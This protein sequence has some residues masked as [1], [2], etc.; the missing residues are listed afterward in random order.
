VRR[1]LAFALAV[2]AANVGA[3]CDLLLQ[4]EFGAREPP[5]E[6]LPIATSAFV[7]DGD[8]TLLG[9]MRVVGPCLTLIILN[10]NTAGE[11]VLPIWPVGFSA[12]GGEGHGIRLTGPMELAK[13]AVDS[14]RLELHGEYVDPA[15]ADASVPAGCER[16][17]LFLVG[18]VRN[19]AT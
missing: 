14:E 3:S 10:G 19:V 13:D 11:R 12:V 16:Y 15:P 4:P 17:R 8:E 2:A 1:C 6:P 7:P 5:P 18:R 9:E